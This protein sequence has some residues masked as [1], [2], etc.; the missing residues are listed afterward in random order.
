MEKLRPL[1]TRI[2]KGKPQV[3]LKNDW[4]TCEYR[5]EARLI[6]R[7]HVYEAQIGRRKGAAF[8]DKLDALADVLQKYRR[9]FG[10][11]FFRRCAQEARN[12]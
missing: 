9:A 7:M 4:L 2:L 6:A 12:A 11:R 5:R 10:S 8:A 3:L 1:P